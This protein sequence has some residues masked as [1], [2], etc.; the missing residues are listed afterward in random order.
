METHHNGII[1]DHHPNAGFL[2]GGV[3]MIRS[4]HDNRVAAGELKRLDHK[5]LKDIGIERYRIM[6]MSNS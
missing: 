1:A 5:I 2:S 4:W 3:K 6:L